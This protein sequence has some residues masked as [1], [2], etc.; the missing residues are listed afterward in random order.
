MNENKVNLQESEEDYDEY[1]TGEWRS[2]MKAYLMENRSE[3][4]KEMLREGR[5]E[6]FLRNHEKEQSE[7]FDNLVHQ[8]A[9]KDGIRFTHSKWGW[10]PIYDGK[11][12]QMRWVGLLNMARAQAREILIQEY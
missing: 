10:D 9:E 4:Y 2:R 7:R 6:S 8:I 11:I 12:P 3:E 5:L 1:A